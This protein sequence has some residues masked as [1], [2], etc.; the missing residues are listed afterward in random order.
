MFISVKF[1]VFCVVVYNG[2]MPLPRS[3]HP[4]AMLSFLLALSCLVISSALAEPVPVV[5]PISPLSGGCRYIPSDPEWPTEAQWSALNTSV[6]GRLI[7]TV[8]LGAPC[9]QKTYNVKTKSYDLSTFNQAAC[10]SVKAGWN[11][12][13]FHET[14]SS[15]V[16]QTYFTNDSCNAID[17]AQDPAGCGIGSYVQYAINVTG[18]ADAL[19]G[20]AFAQKY[21]IRLLIKN[22][23]HE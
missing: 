4:F 5:R 7:A 3:L 20:M 11:D 21:N 14:S 16:M 12:P 10:D 19:A 1:T 23:G 18:D 22:T 6:G 15:S 8:P 13:A 2:N 17:P 9:F